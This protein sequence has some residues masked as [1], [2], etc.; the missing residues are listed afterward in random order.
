MPEDKATAEAA[1]IRKLIRGG[2]NALAAIDYS[3]TLASVTHVRAKKRSF[4]SHGSFPSSVEE[5]VLDREVSSLLQ[6][7]EPAQ[8][9]D[10]RL[11]VIKDCISNP[12][13]QQ[14]LILVNG[15]DGK[16]PRKIDE[17]AQEMGITE[18]EVKTLFD[19]DIKILRG[20]NSH[21]T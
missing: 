8:I 16:P 5:E 7:S 14:V 20:D 10:P 18:A 2:S 19:Q 12:L 11:K 17:I 6:K 21:T 9:L 15:L 4:A 13:G 3:P 1:T